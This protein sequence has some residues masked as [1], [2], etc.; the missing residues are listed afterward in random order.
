MINASVTKWT[1]Q[2][3]EFSLN[4]T[5]LATLAIKDYIEENKIN[6]AK[7]VTSSWD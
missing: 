4:Y 5:K 2:V 6:L 7:D 3:I 1:A